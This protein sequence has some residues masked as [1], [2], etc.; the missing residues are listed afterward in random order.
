MPRTLLAGPTSPMAGPP[1]VPQ[2][3]PAS[4]RHIHYKSSEIHKEIFTHE[5]V[6][7]IKENDVPGTKLDGK[8]AFRTL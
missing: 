7:S 8:E 5:T 4:I 3:W 6:V 2:T 1:L